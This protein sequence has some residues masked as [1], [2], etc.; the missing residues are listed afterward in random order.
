MLVNHLSIVDVLTPF[1]KR[2]VG[3]IDVALD[4]VKMSVSP[5]MRLKIDEPLRDQVVTG[6]RDVRIH[7]ECVVL[8]H[9]F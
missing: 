6:C 7:R 2:F 9:I 3:A 5:K 8:L 1:V 4:Q